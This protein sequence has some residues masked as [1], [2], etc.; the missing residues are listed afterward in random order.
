MGVRGREPAR[1]R[2][3]RLRVF[4]RSTESNAVTR[5]ISSSRTRV[6]QVD[7]STSRGGSNRKDA[8]GTTSFKRVSGARQRRCFSIASKPL[9]TGAHR[10]IR[11]HGLDGHVLPEL[12]AHRA[13]AR[14]GNEA[15]GHR[16]KFFE[17]FLHIAEAMT[18]SARKS[19]LWTKGDGIL[20][21]TCCTYRVSTLS[22]SGSARSWG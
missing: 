17:N 5:G 19:V 11:W 20:L 2:L 4:F 16:S 22:R 13:R 12:D 1:A 9:P 8:E 6:P 18:R 21:R 15:R 10:P 14:S 7:E 3:G